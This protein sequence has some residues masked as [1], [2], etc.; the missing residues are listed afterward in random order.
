MKVSSKL[1][2]LASFS[3]F[4]AQR[5][6][7]PRNHVISLLGPHLQ[8]AINFWYVRGPAWQW[9]RQT[10][11]GTRGSHK[12]H[13]RP[14]CLEFLEKANFHEINE[15]FQVTRPLSPHEH[16]PGLS[17]KRPGTSFESPRPTSLRCYLCCCSKF[18]SKHQHKTLNT[19]PLKLKTDHW[20]TG[21]YMLSR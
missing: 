8:T 6:R 10:R 15:G 2:Y 16:R 12:M 5:P 21:D 7:F 18:H 3:T 20:T 14:G 19:K 17:S 13:N 9:S 4:L 11:G 1:R